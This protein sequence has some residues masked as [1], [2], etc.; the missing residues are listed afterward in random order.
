MRILLPGNEQQ[1]YSEGFILLRELMV[2]FVVIIC[3][4][5][6]LGAGV[7]LSRQGSRLLENTQLEIVRQ[8]EIV[9]RRLANETY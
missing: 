9:L 8:N 7:V 3:F 2:M 5:A 6:V 1:R 4:A